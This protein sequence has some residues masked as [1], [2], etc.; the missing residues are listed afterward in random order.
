VQCGHE[1]LEISFRSKMFSIVS[2]QE[3]W[4][5]NF[6]KD[7]QVPSAFFCQYMKYTSS[8]SL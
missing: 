6:P 5:I 8:T 7:F 2:K 4:K 1:T 3:N